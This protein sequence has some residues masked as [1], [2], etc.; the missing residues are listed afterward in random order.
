M[1]PD[2]VGAVGIAKIARFRL[3]PRENR[4]DE[5]FYDVVGDDDG[6]FGCMTLLGCHDV[7]P[8]ELPL[9][10]Q[11]AYVRRLMVRTGLK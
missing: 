7:C 4:D 11:I 9:L 10:T 3:D 8:K 2:F 5:A 6:V 1:R